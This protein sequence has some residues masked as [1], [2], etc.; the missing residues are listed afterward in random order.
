MAPRLTFQH[1]DEVIQVVS[2]D[3]S[4]VVEPKLFKQGGARARDHAPCI[5]IDL[6]GRL[7]NRVGQLL[8]DTLCDLSQLSEWFVCLKASQGTG[9]GTHGV[10]I[11]S[12][13]LC[14]QRNLKEQK[15]GCELSAHS[16]LMFVWIEWA[17][18][19]QPTFI[20]KDCDRSLGAGIR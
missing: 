18:L 10:L 14:G 8:R 4:N 2:I 20:G 13:V 19:A 17:V 12:V 11:L 9:Q 16:I 15:G 7:L 1:S 6:G 3:W 5:L